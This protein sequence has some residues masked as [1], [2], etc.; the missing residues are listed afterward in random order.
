MGLIDEFGD[1]YY[2]QNPHL[3]IDPKSFTITE[4]DYNQFCKMVESRDVPYKSD[5]RI[6]VEKLRKA[7][8]KERYADQTL[9]QAMA[10]IEKNLKDDKM[11]NL[12]TYKSDIVRTINADIVVRYAYA[13]GRTAN[14]IAH[15]KGI[16]AAIEMLGDTARMKQILTTQDT[17][18]NFICVTIDDNEDHRFN[19]VM[20]IQNLTFT[21]ICHLSDMKTK[22]GI[23]R[24]D[25]IGYIIRDI[26]NYSN[27]LGMQLK[28]VYNRESVTDTDFYVRTIKF[29]AVQPNSLQ[30][31]VMNNRYEFD[32]YRRS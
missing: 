3:Q 8:N 6:A 23:D 32:T 26:F 21:V 2:R 25:L 27:I 15:D 1:N 14:G 9:S 10:A 30:K 11:N 29:E 28:L 7:L 4:Q 20:K 24:H 19:E 22:Y 5:S 13:E 17:V 12:T 18:R 16:A 31:G